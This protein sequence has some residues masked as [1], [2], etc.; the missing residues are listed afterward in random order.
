MQPQ[1]HVQTLTRMLDH[2]QQPQA[3]CDAAR[4]R[5]HDGTSIDVEAHMQADV[6]SDLTAKGHQIQPV[7]DS[8]MDFGSGQFIWRLCD[9]EDATEAIQTGYVAA[10]DSRRDG[11]AACC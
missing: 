6:I 7:S 11:Y 8:Y 2:Q 3:A 9:A 4:W 1:G 5:V 10:S